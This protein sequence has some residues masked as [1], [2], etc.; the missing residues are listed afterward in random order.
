[1]LHTIPEPRTFTRYLPTGW[2]LPVPA[3]K[4]R[5]LG[6]VPI[7]YEFGTAN[8]NFIVYL[9]RRPTVVNPSQESVS[10]TRQAVVRSA[11]IETALQ[12]LAVS[13]QASSLAKLK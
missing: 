13:W 8:W 2:L 6:T 5:D 10:C 9:R 3:N 12:S 11:Q 4:H 7:V 1:M